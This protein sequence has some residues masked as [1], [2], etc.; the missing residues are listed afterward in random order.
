[1]LDAKLYF[2]ITTV[3]GLDKV[4]ISYLNVIINLQANGEPR[5]LTY[6]YLS[7]QKMF[8]IT[9]LTQMIDFDCLLT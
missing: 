9:L 7:L 3:V 5:A 6:C 1:M 2:I 8:C 4:C